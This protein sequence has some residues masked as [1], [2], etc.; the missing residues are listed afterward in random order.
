MAT[1]PL[2]G[3]DLRNSNYHLTRTNLP[4]RT[5]IDLTVLA[6]LIH[7]L[8]KVIYS[9]LKVIYSIPGALKNKTRIEIPTDY[10]RAML[11]V[12]DEEGVLEYGEV[13]IQYS[14]DIKEPRANVHVHQG[15]WFL[16]FPATYMK[17][18]DCTN[19]D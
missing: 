14:D 17:Q 2:R 8:I 5:E 16:H 6:V 10:G 1:I 9:H 15:W 18:Q 13:F 3:S 4:G 12:M 19:E 11:G 7:T